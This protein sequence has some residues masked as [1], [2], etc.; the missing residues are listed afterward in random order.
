[1]K[2]DLSTQTTEWLQK[3]ER[4]LNILKKFLFFS[5]FLTLTAGIIVAVAKGKYQFLALLGINA[6]LFQ[7]FRSQWTEVNAELETR[8]LKSG[9]GS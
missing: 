7:K 5:L 1:M 2:K 4:K 8:V 9:I 3:Q 6:I